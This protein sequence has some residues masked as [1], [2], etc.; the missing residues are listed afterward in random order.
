M[1]SAALHDLLASR[2]PIYRGIS[3]PS[4][5]KAR[6]SGVPEID[7]L[8]AHHGQPGVPQGALTILRGQPGSGRTSTAA[9]ILAHATQRAQPVAWI[10]VEGF[11]YPPALH[12]HHLQLE[13]LLII[14]PSLSQSV[15]AA[16]QVL[17]S[18]LFSW[19]ALTGFTDI[20]HT[21]R[22]RRVL[23]AVQTGETSGLVIL[24]SHHTMSIRAALELEL[25]RKQEH[26]QVRLAGL[27][28]SEVPDQF[29]ISVR[30]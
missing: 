19:V 10:D 25:Q 14:Q 20:L 2:Y 8:L 17:R 1:S 27:S 16:E 21:K 15:Y 3:R 26:I 12:Q 9:R 30:A 18:G 4:Y 24:D 11:I 23:H 29:A 5:G 13:R 22:A 7:Q 6:T 28:G